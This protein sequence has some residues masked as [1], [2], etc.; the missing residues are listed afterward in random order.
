MITTE[1]IMHKAIAKVVA[2]AT[3]VDIQAIAE[4]QVEWTHNT[5]GPKI[6]SHTMKWL[7]FDWDAEDKFSELN[8]FRL[9]V[10]NLLSTYNTPQTDKLALVKTGWEEKASGI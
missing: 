7:T 10:N 2:E 1:G 6:G 5:A 9:E 8:T 3:R 4:A